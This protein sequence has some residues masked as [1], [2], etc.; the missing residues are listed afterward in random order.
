MSMSNLHLLLDIDGFSVSDN[1]NTKYLCKELAVFNFSTK[2]S[3]LFRFRLHR[4]LKSLT[5]KDR[6][7]ARFVTRHIHSLRFKDYSKDLNQ[8]LLPTVIKHFA[9]FCNVHSKSI[10]YKGGH[11]EK[12]LLI[13]A[14][15]KNILNI[16]LYGIPKFDVLNT[17][18]QVQELAATFSYRI[19]FSSSTKCNRHGINRKN[20]HCPMTEVAHFAAWLF[21]HDLFDKL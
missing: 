5:G 1:Y 14:G 12:D 4:T 6:K 21:L 3:Y 2:T 16:E 9:D 8:R 18:E 15:A 7:S 20:Y 13:K 17:D 10:G 19:A 11:L